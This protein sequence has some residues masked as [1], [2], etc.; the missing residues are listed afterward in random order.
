VERKKSSFNSKYCSSILVDVLKKTAVNLSQNDPCPGQGKHLLN[1]SKSI[2]KL[3]STVSS[4]P[5]E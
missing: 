4:K 5:E 3:P 2:T 1:A